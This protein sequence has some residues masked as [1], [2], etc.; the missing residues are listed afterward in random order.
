MLVTV[1]LGINAS[2]YTSQKIVNIVNAKERTV[3]KDTGNNAD[4]EEVVKETIRT[5]AVKSV[6]LV[7]TQIM[8]G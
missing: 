1:N 3:L 4:L 7:L 2:R 8:K 5:I 6:I